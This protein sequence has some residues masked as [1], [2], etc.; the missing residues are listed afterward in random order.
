M[1][2]G[3]FGVTIVAS[4]GHAQMILEIGDGFVTIALTE[5][6]N[7]T[8]EMTMALSLVVPHCQEM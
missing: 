3:A 8:T 2:T 1:I 5:V 6:I 7:A 4:A